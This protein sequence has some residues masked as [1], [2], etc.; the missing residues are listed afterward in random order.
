MK[1]YAAVAKALVNEF[2][3]LQ[4]QLHAP[5][6]LPW[7]PLNRDWVG[8]IASLDTLEMRKSHTPAMNRT[9]FLIHPAHSPITLITV[10][11]WLPFAT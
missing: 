2:K 5:A 10:L 3:P 6:T 7:F 8:S 4:Q 9:Q 11:S 1:A